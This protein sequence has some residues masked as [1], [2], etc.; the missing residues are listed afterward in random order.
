MKCDVCGGSEDL[1]KPAI[2][3]V[4]GG[5]LPKVIC[6]ECFGQ[7]YDGDQGFDSWEAIGEYVKK[8]RQKHGNKR[9]RSGC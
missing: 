5:F 8:R 6:S 4:Q 1:R 9:I 7:W 2:G 3:W